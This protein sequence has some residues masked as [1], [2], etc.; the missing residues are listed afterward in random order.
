MQA[1]FAHSPKYRHAHR[2]APWAE[3]LIC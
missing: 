3:R 2:T 1:A